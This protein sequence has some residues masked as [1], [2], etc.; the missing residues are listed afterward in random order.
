M[1]TLSCG[2]LANTFQEDANFLDARY[3]GTHGNRPAYGLLSSRIRNTALATGTA[4]PAAVRTL[5]AFIADC[6]PKKKDKTQGPSSNHFE[7]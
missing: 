6:A 3:R 4:P 2:Q 1:R 7:Q 5:N